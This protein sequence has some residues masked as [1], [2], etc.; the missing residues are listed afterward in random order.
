MIFSMM[1]VAWPKK[2][3]DGSPEILALCEL[4]SK[5]LVSP[6]ISPIVVPYIIPYIFPFK[7]FRL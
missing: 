4:L 5:F 2:A 6:L 3:Q 1:V 7:E